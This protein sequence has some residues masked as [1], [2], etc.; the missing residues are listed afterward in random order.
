LAVLY[1]SRQWGECRHIRRQKQCRSIDTPRLDPCRRHLCPDCRGRSGRGGLADRSGRCRRAS[2][3]MSTDVTRRAGAIRIDTGRL[4]PCCRHLC[5]D[6]RG[7]IG[8]GALAARSRRCRRTSVVMG[9]QAECGD[10]S[11]AHAKKHPTKLDPQ[12]ASPIRLLRTWACNRSASFGN[13]ESGSQFRQDFVLGRKPM[14]IVL[15]RDAPARGPDFVSS[16]ANALR[17]YFPA[18][19]L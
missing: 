4:D 6:C 10:R 19:C 11:D 7:R 14:L 2:V 15:A 9:T 18:P 16:L 8:R 1:G 3:V 12:L 5:P 13:R 17:R